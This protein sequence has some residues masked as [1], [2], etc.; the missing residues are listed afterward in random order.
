MV[1]LVGSRVVVVDKEHGEA[2]DKD[3]DLS[4][5]VTVVSCKEVAE[6]T[7]LFFFLAMKPN[8]SI[9]YCAIKLDFSSA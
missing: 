5:V 3:E 1:H 8:C 4:V 6:V 7:E 9:D 2:V